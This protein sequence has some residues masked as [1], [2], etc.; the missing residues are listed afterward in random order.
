M[1]ASDLFLKLETGVDIPIPELQLICH[2]PTVKEI[3]MMGES[4]FFTAMQYLCINKEVIPQGETV[5]QTLTNF[6]I[7]MKVLKESE[8]KTRK[9]SLVTL[10]T[11]LFPSYQVVLMPASIN[12]MDEETTVMVDNENFDTLQDAVSQILCVNSLFQ[13]DN[14]VYNTKSKK[15]QEIAEKIYKGR[16]KVAQIKA[17]EG[18]GSILLRYLSILQIGTRIPLSELVNFN[19]FQL[20]DAMER[21]TAFTEWDTDLQ[22]RLAG[23]KPDNQV[24][25]WMRDLHS[26][27]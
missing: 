18:S 23:G 21:Y 10:L 3:A 15:A 25:S 22:V 24:E 2:S 6:Q 20:F 26:N 9:A 5:L 14:I 17:K 16:S 13:S 1:T 7:L 19:L 11:L 12:F 27:K 4:E 8:D